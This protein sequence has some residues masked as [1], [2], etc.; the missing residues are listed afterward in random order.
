MAWG[1]P[2]Q[3]AAI[4]RAP[5]AANSPVPEPLRVVLVNARLLVNRTFISTDFFTSRGLDFLRVTETWVAVC[6]F[7]ELL[8]AD[9]TYFNSPTTSGRG[10]VFPSVYSDS[11][12]KL[13]Y[14]DSFSLVQ[15]VSGP[16]QGRGYTFDLV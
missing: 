12:N 4:A 5:Q 6:E 16:T 2:V 14:S 7:C 11:Y 8:P 3:P 10:R 15:F 1:E 9:W 13:F